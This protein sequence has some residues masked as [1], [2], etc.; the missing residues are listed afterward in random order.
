VGG[1]VG[2]KKRGGE[3]VWGFF[4]GERRGGG[5]GDMTGEEFCKQMPKFRYSGR[6]LT[7][8]VCIH[9]DI[10]SSLLSTH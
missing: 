7:S 9:G 6:T 5:G 10:K 8:H 2:R 1:G 4:C 3:W